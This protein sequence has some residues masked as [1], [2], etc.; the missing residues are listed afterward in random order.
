MRVV[1]DDRWKRKKKDLIGE[2]EVVI[3]YVM[4]MRHMSE[5]PLLVLA[6]VWT[7]WL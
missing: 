3:G 6:S 4:P 7:P 5:R 2:R 1:L